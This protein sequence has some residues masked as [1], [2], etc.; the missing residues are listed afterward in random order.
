MAYPEQ[1]ETARLQL[2]RFRPEDLAELQRVQG[3]PRIG[4]EQFPMRFRTP[5]MVERFLGTALA[6][7]ERYG[8]G[9]WLIRLDGEAIGRAGLAH[10]DLDGRDVIEVGWFLSPDHWGRGYATEA[11]RAA[12]D[13]GFT[14]LGLPEIL[15]WTMPTN[16]PSQAVMRRFGFQEIGPIERAGLPHVAYRVTPS[17]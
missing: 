9:H 17:G 7:W 16:V 3:D 6:H 5:E 12:I 8:F 4:E 15:A 14:H 2:H 11:S 13:A 1:L 10:A